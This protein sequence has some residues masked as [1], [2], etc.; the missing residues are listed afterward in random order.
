MSVSLCSLGNTSGGGGASG[1]TSETINGVTYGNILAK[2]TDP[3]Y[4]IHQAGASGTS[5]RIGGSLTYQDF[6]SHNDGDPLNYFVSVSTAN[7]YYTLANITGASNGG[8]LY[9][10]VTPATNGG[11]QTIRITLDGTA[12]TFVKNC[13]STARLIFGNFGLADFDNPINYIHAFGQ[14]G[15]DAFTSSTAATVP[16]TGQ[17]LVQTGS[18]A[19]K[20]NFFKVFFSSSCKVEVQTTTIS[21]AYSGHVPHYKKAFCSIETL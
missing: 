1:A 13:G 4:L 11:N 19:S 2:P 17:A 14:S 8:F 16:T 12:Y 6:Q 3:G 7:T 10:I 20:G 21:T 5:M 9:N 15:G 18:V